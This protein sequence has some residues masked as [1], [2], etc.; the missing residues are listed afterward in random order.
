MAETRKRYEEALEEMKGPLVSED[1]VWDGIDRL[2]YLQP[3]KWEMI[4][5]YD[6]VQQPTEV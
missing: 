5:P 1:A 2:M 3:W 6:P 4:G